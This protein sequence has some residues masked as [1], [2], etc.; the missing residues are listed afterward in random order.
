MSSVVK[1]DI[2]ELDI[3]VDI[4]NQVIGNTSRRNDIAKSIELEQCLVVK[5]DDGIAGF[6]LY[7]T[8]FFGCT[9]ISLIIVSPLKRRK[10]YAS[11]LINHLE[12]IAPTQKVFSSTNR[13]NTAMQKV[14]DLNGFIE[15]GFVDNLDEGDPELIYYKSKSSFQPRR[16]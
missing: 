5:E 16:L 2:K 9:F 11:L 8:N 12:S 13:S 1:A 6:L 15:S 10:G 14:F 3:I 4:D 7:D